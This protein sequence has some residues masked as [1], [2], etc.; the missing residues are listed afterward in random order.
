MTD[1]QVAVMMLSILVITIL[2]GFPIC[3]TLMGLGV[4]FGYYAYYDP[5]Y[6][7][8]FFDPRIEEGLHV[9][10]VVVGVVAEADAEPHEGETDREAEQDGDDQDAEH[11][12]SDL[13]VGHRALPP[14]PLPSS[15]S[16]WI[17]SS[18]W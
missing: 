6:M 8:T 16:S 10:G 4:G 5:S 7:E 18:C 9:G 11:H 1:P 14:S 3:F 13:W 12:H 17:S 15:C 2:L